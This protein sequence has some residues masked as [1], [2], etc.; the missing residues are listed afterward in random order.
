M[1]RHAALIPLS[2][3]H[4]DALALSVFI[5][6]GL[7]DEPTIAKARALRSQ[8]TDTF[9]LLLRGH[10]EVEESVVFPAA[11][12][13]LPDPGLIDGLLDDHQSLRQLFKNLNNHAD[14]ELIAALKEL[15][16]QLDRH[17]RTEERFLFQTMQE[18]FDDS[19]MATLGNEI[20]AKLNVVCLTPTL[21]QS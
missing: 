8:A 9:E 2:H 16:V 18:V 13:H 19:M 17:I 21:K 4:H 20:T 11:R 7:R 14:S 6:R 3:Q 15:G 10:F 1:K 12:A 5:D